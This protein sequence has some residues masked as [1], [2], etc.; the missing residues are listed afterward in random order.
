MKEFFTWQVLA[1]YG[2][3][4]LLVNLVTQLLK[5]IVPEGAPTRLVS[6]LTA[7]VIL[8]AANIFTG[9]ATGAADIALCFINALV[10]ALAANGAYDAATKMKK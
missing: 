9:A 5:G 1:S 7:V 6:Y 2:G 10:V 4:V 3:A 8:I